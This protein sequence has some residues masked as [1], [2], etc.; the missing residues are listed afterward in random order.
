MGKAQIPS[1]GF[2]PGDE[3]TAHAM[4]ENVFLDDVVRAAEWYAWLPRV[5]AE[6]AG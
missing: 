4:N 3:T 6:Q 2:G 1:I 5:L